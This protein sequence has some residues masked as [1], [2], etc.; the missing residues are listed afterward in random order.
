MDEY[1]EQAAQ[2]INQAWK[3]SACPEI[4]LKECLIFQFSKAL[5]TLAA[6]R[7]NWRK[8]YMEIAKP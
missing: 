4:S 6:E 2:C 1:D 3:D 7:D 8:A 5:R